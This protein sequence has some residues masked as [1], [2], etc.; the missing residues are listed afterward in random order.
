[1]KRAIAAVIATVGIG[2]CLAGPAFAQNQSYRRVLEDTVAMVG[3]ANAQR[4]AR[5]RGLDVVNVTWED[6]GRYKGSAVGD[7][8]SDMTI[9]VQEKDPVT[10]KSRLYLMPVI[11]KPNFSDVT[12]DVPLD[13]FFLLVGNERGAAPER[14]SLRDYLGDIRRYLHEPTSWAGKTRSLLADRDTHA[15]VSAQAAF[16]PIPR[17]GEATFNPVLFNYQS[18]EGDPAVLTI[19]VTR[20]GTSATIIDNKRDAFEAGGVWGQR[21]FFNKDGQRASLTGKRLSDAQVRL[22]GGEATPAGPSAAGQE[23]LNMV[24]LIQVPLKQKNPMAFGL[25][26]GECDDAMAAPMERA[27]G[28]SDVENA[29]IGHGALEGPFTELA[30]LPIER[31]PRFPVRVTVQFYK[32]TSNG[33][34]SAADL[35]AVKAQIDRV[36]ADG[37]YVGSLVTEGA[38]NRP[39]EHDGPKTEPDGW[40]SAFWVRYQ[41]NLGLS[42]EEA[43]EVMQRL[44]VP[45]FVAWHRVPAPLVTPAPAPPVK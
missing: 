35:D 15:L 44:Y 13:R 22:G 19:L 14:V 21:L 36:Y 2:P 17:G 20:E 5:E 3:D 24:L 42:R 6:T 16:L 31:D 7:N 8:I 38:T 43:L 10:G 37:T 30:G 12:A 34:V 23:G 32:A 9:Q 27:R 25:M 40:W 26:E 39:T 18:Y 1:M 41:G 29:V 4:L 33:V 45:G 11:R 28:A